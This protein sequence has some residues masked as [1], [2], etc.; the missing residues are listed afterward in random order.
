MPLFQNLHHPFFPTDEDSPP[1]AHF[2]N[3]EPYSSRVFFVLY[4]APAEADVVAAEA[5]KQCDH[6]A[7]LLFNLWPIA[8]ITI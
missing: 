6:M 7:L 3:F 1:P 4:E 8:P 2:C 5:S